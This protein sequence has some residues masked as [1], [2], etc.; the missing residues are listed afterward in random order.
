MLFYFILDIFN[1]S[2][3]NIISFE[4]AKVLLLRYIITFFKLVFDMHMTL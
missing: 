4:A 2:E 3:N 1:L